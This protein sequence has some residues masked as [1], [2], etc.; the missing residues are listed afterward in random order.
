M[1]KDGKWMG[2]VVVLAACMGARGGMWDN[3]V[4]SEDFSSDPSANWTYS[5][6]Q[7]GSSQDLFRWNASGYVDA[8]WDQSNSFT[9]SGD[10]YTI[11]PSSYSRSLGETL[12]DDHRFRFGATLNLSSVANTTE[13]YQVASFGLYGLSDMGAD[14]TMSDNFSGNSTLVKDGSDFVEFNYFI[15]NDSFGWNAN[16]GA[17]MG[18]HITGDTGDYTTGAS[19]DGMYHNTDM[20]KDNW[21]PTGADLYIQVTYYG[22]TTRRAHMGVYTDAAHT[23]LLSVNG[24]EQYY[25][26]Q[27][28]PG[29]DHFTL[30]DVALFNYAASNW[31]GTNG[32]GAGMFDDVYVQT[33]EPMTMATLLIGGAGLLAARRR[34]RAIR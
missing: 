9:G 21:L 7:N 6:Q 3:T 11:A 30:T 13:F 24:V 32:S 29:D 22:T 8:E 31:G 1:F 25:W 5:G 18:A 10:P 16:T 27:A 34:R 23:T 15:N 20:G 33:P 2:V 17:A 12:T 26:T 4:L 28:L 19:S 14:R